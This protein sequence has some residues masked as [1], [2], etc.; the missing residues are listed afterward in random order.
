MTNHMEIE[1]SMELA[2]FDDTIFKILFHIFLFIVLILSIYF[3]KKTTKTCAC[4]ETCIACTLMDDI[5][6]L[7]NSHDKDMLLHLV[8]YKINDKLKFLRWMVEND[9]I[10]IKNKIEIIRNY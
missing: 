1:E 6:Q 2:P 8:D 7:P 3:I 4:E 9:D 10:P 5:D